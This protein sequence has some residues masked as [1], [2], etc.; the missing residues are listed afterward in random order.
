MRIFKP[1][2]VLLAIVALL[3]Y[4]E[5]GTDLVSVDQY[6]SP[7]LQGSAV[8]KQDVFAQAF[9]QGRSN[10]Q[11]QGKGRVVRLLADD[12]DGSRHQRFILQLPSGQTLLVA[13]NIDLAPRIEGLTTGDE[14]ELYGEYEWNAEGGVMHWT[15]RDPQGR[16][17]GGWIRHGGR[18]Y[19]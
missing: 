18:T 19:R 12:N 5:S 13:H 17:D 8:Q 2:L 11:L 16:R 14:V 10:L 7:V 15:H 3:R 6:G 4:V 9:A 1:M